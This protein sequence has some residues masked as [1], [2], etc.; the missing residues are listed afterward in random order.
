MSRNIH[1]NIE[2]LRSQAST[3]ASCSH[4]LEQAVK[5][6]TEALNQI[7]C[8]M[9]I[10]SVVSR[11]YS[12]IVASL[13]SG[14]SKQSEDL[15]N[16]LIAFESQDQNLK[17][18]LDNY[19]SSETIETVN[20]LCVQQSLSTVPGTKQMY[21]KSPNPTLYSSK[22]D[23]SYYGQCTTVV[24]AVLLN[25]RGALDGNNSKVWSAQDV[26]HH[27]D[28][29]ATYKKKNGPFD[30]GEHKYTYE[31]IHKG[32]KGYPNSI[33]DFV[34][35]L[36]D[37]EEGITFYRPHGSDHHAI[38]ISDYEIV[39]YD[40]NNNPQYQFYAYDGSGK[41]P[42]RQRLE[43]TWLYKSACHSTSVEE[44][45]FSG[46]DESSYVAFLNASE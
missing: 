8:E 30:C 37:H 31:D 21:G 25:R 32:E 17:K 33:E 46:T 40:E 15:V 9:A 7:G 1:V 27:N 22:P 45:L 44:L 38:V 10:E 11:V 20:Y 18:S 6:S 24:Q 42:D 34:Q 2:T 12:W 43:D 39:G 28:N 14:L 41:N 19:F 29:G 13:V 35:L 36:E 23:S 26:W 5:E 4:S 16:S 3:I